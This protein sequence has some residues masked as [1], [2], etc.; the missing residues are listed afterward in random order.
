MLRV[1]LR[2]KLHR[3]TVTQIELNHE[4]S[5]AVDERNRA[6]EV[7]SAPTAPPRP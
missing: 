5:C 2:S 4:G 1:L 7:T 6:V 3:V